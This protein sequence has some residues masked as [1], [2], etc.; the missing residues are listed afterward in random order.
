MA[1]LIVVLYLPHFISPKIA[2]ELYLTGRDVP[3]HE[4]RELGLVNRIVKAADLEAKRRSLSE[5]FR[6][7]IP[8]HCV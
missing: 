3:A 5:R 4:A 2:S 6:R 1:P 8:R 7:L